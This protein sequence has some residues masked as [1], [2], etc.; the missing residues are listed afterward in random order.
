MSEKL[1]KLKLSLKDAK[2]EEKGSR[3]AMSD[4]KKAFTDSP[5]KSSGAVLRTTTAA[6]AKDKIKV[7]GLNDKIAAAA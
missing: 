1:K 2:A 6:W 4:A 3:T 7:S 5:D